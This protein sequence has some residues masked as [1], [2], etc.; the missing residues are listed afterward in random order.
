[1][2]F[3]ASATASQTE[4]VPNKINF[5][6]TSI[7]SD[8][9]I[10]SRRIFIRGSDGNFIVQLGTSTQYEVWS[11]A[12]LSIILTLLSKDISAAITIQWLDGSNVVLYDYS[13]NQGFTL[14]NETFDYQLTQRLTGNTLLINDNDFFPLKSQLRVAIDSGN[15]AILKGDIFGAQQCYDIGTN[16]RV[17]SQYYFNANA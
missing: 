6:D 1:M 13:F 9:A 10:V 4:G 8:G 14:F 11:I 7:G 17:N 15:Q 16:L 3:I 2:A 12:S 5:L